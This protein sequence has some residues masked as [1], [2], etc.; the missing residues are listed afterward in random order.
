MKSFLKFILA[1]LDYAMIKNWRLA[2]L[3]EQAQKLASIVE[4]PKIQSQWVHQGIK[5]NS[6]IDYGFISP[7]SPNA[8]DLQICE[9]LLVYYKNCVVSQDKTRQD[10]TKQKKRIYGKT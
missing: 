5:E 9:R 3:E 7:I 8:E 6:K 1:K 4:I 2:S 10:K